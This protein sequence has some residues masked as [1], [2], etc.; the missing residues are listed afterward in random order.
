M[1]AIA[2]ATR[3]LASRAPAFAVPAERINV[4]GGEGVCVCVCVCVCC[5]CVCGTLHTLFL[6]FSSLFSS[7][8]SFF[9]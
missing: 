8:S 2:A 9:Y 7:L 1:A 6:L 3:L 4:R 5:V